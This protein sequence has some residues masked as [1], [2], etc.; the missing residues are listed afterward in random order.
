MRRTTSFVL[1]ALAALTVGAD[2][3]HAC[4][5]VPVFN[6]IST[7]IQISELEADPVLT[8]TDTA[9]EWI[10]LRNVSAGTIAMT[11]WTLSDNGGS[12]VLPALSLAPGAC[13]LVV[14]TTDGFLAE[15][16]GH[17]APL[18][19]VAD[20]SIGNGLANGGDSLT[21]QDPTG[22]VVDCVV[23]GSGAGCFT[24]TVPVTG[25]N[26]PETLQR[27]AAAD[28]DAA[29]DWAA[30]GESPC[31]GL[32]TA[33][34]LVSFRARVAGR[35][36]LLTWRTASELDLVGFRVWRADAPGRAFRPIGVRLVPARGAGGR[37]AYVDR[38][39]RQRTVLRY[40]L[41]LVG[42]TGRSRWSSVIVVSP[43]KV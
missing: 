40:R 34:A 18:T 21:L 42:L 30:A 9:N 28:T 16:P 12:D 8:G 37:Y 22:S 26:T 19:A 29:G 33:V 15:H 38:Q 4:F 39:P 35:G 36:I 10:E 20:G 23:W 41:Q 25:A 31:A 17:P 43:R 24:P 11:D 14:A 32:P 5:S 6:A 1:F 27:G 7:S 2:A 13:A 3:A